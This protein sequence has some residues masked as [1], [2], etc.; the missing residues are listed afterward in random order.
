VTPNQRDAARW[1]EEN[2]AFVEENEIKMKS[3]KTTL[4][5]ALAAVGVFL[6]TQPGLELAGQIVSGLA[7]FLLGAFARDNSVTSE[8]AG[9]KIPAS[10]RD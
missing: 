2:A 5:G 8:Q 1:A 4:F 3:W 7:T 10:V 9:A 6:S